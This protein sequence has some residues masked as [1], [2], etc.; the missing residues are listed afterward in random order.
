ML[1]PLVNAVTYGKYEWTSKVSV[2]ELIVTAA[3]YIGERRAVDVVNAFQ[4]PIR[5]R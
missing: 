3:A 4:N 1:S 5:Y 2:R